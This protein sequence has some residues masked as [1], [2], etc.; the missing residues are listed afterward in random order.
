MRTETQIQGISRGAMR[1]MAPSLF[2]A[3]NTATSRIRPIR[4]HEF[5]TLEEQARVKVRYKA[6]HDLD[7]GW[8]VREIGKAVRRY[9]EARALQTS[10]TDDLFG[11]APQVAHATTGR[12]R[13]DQ[14]FDLTARVNEILKQ[15]LSLDDIDIAM[16]LKQH[17]ELY[18]EIKD[19][20]PKPRPNLRV[21]SQPKPEV[22]Q[23][24]K[25]ALKKPGRRRND[26]EEF[27]DLPTA[28][29]AA[30]SLGRPIPLRTRDRQLTRRWALADGTVLTA[31]GFSIDDV[32]QASN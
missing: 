6:I 11:D 1:K 26:V 9:T 19:E 30:R 28:V 13:K 32:L 24:F 7:E 15:G 25:I 21:L 8:R 31:Q 20:K 14:V 17:P 3:A 10:Q 18:D 12:P 5:L 2:F 22:A 29:Q 4:R 23:P 16:V 27:E